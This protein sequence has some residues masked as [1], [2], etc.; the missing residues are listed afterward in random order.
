[1]P[2]FSPSIPPRPATPPLGPAPAPLFSAPLPLKPATLPLF[3]PSMRQKGAPPPLRPARTPPQPAS[4][5]LP[6]PTPPLFSTQA[7]STKHPIKHFPCRPFP[8]G[9]APSAIAPHRRPFGKVGRP[10]PVSSP[11]LKTG[12]GQRPSP[13]PSL[14]KGAGQRPSPSPPLKK[15]AGR[16]AAPDGGFALDLAVSKPTPQPTANPNQSTHTPKQ[17]KPHRCGFPSTPSPEIRNKR[18][19]H[20]ITPVPKATTCRPHIH[21]Y[22]GTASSSSCRDDFANRAPSSL[23]NPSSPWFLPDTLSNA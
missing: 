21:S 20:P 10:P 22:S 11:P 17:K 8:S 23:R 18:G 5:P 16:R 13:S 12:A 1:M 6:T 14:K 9:T 19:R 7:S 2:L 15:G 4:L 3:S